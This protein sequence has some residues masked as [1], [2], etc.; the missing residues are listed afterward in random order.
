MG[1]TIERV[2]ID[3][4]WRGAQR[5]NADIAGKP[6]ALP[7]VNPADCRIMRRRMTDRLDSWKAIA[8]YLQR[9]ERTVRRWEQELGLPVRRVS[10][11]R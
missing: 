4:P 1:I 11:E 10:G 3:V 7:R 5:T 8:E 2:R 9:T 6:A